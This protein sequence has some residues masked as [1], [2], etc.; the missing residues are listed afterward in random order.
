MK[1][2]EIL[3][4]SIGVFLTVIAWLIADIYHTST[5]DKIKS[6]INLPQINRYEIN[7]D[8]LETLKNMTE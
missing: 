6:K 3:L 1:R 7:K 5:E 2:K 4:L 8:L